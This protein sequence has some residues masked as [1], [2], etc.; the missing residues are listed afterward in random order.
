MASKRIILPAA[1]FLAATITPV[2]AGSA[3][4]AAPVTPRVL[5]VG[6]V[7]PQQLAGVDPFALKVRVK[8]QIGGCPAGCSLV[9]YER[10]GRQSE[11]STEL[12]TLTT[13]GSAAATTHI[14]T[15]TLKRNW[16][17]ADS[18]YTIRDLATGDET[19]SFDVQ[20]DFQPEGALTYSAG[21]VRDENAGATETMLMRSS[22]AGSTA[23]TTTAAAAQT[24]GVISA[25]G[26][27]NGVMSVAVNG[28]TKQTIDLNAATWQPRQLVAALTVPAHSTLTL[29]NVSPATR[30]HKDV[31]VDGL[32]RLDP[33]GTASGANLGALSTAGPVPGPVQAESIGATLVNGQQLAASPTAAK[34]S[35][36]ANVLG[37]P[38]GCTITRE[39][40]NDGTETTLLSRT[41]PASSVFQR[42]SFTD[43]LPASDLGI[44]YTLSKHGIPLAATTHFSPEYVPDTA[45]VYSH[46]WT[47]RTDA[48]AIGGTL[49]RSNTAGGVGATYAVL[50][51]FSG[52]NVAVVATRGPSGG[53]MTVSINGVPVEKVDL[54]SATLQPRRVVGV[55]Q[56]P[57]E[58]ISGRLTV[59]NSTPAGRAGNVVDFDGLMLLQDRDDWY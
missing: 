55:V 52:R 9:K 54:Y 38:A 46:G 23:R 49:M 5:S 7:A 1:A 45:L 29:S 22:A 40:A 20:P 36:V 2:G 6:I 18:Y 39:N 37:C 26:P 12:T 24:I 16:Y 13:P 33:P 14:F 42:L 34:V 43:T 47:R 58:P 51:T 27:N 44:S 21:W 50:G 59:L 53:V 10:F 25:K 32:V 48:G 41:S 56:V 4:A 30:L 35:V 11:Q 19:G 28:V 8:Y 17:Q 31:H 3:S 57:L 15:D